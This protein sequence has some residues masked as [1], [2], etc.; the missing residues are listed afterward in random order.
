MD[1]RHF[2]IVIILRS[3]PSN[4]PLN[5]IGT[6]EFTTEFE[7]EKLSVTVH[8]IIL[9]KSVE[10]MSLSRPRTPI[11]LH[12]LHPKKPQRFYRERLGKKSFWKALEHPPVS[13]LCDQPPRA[14]RI[15][16]P[17]ARSCDPPG[18]AGPP[19]DTPPAPLYFYIQKNL[20]GYLQKD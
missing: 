12:F 18:R 3:E 7:L 4:L 19:A 10:N 8:S 1:T 6:I 16:C 20:N 5:L 15:E 14:A 9:S 17:S 13:E 11:N 2:V